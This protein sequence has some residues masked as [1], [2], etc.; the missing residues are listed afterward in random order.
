MVGEVYALQAQLMQMNFGGGDTARNAE[1]RA[2]MT[3]VALAFI[4]IAAVVGVVGRAMGIAATIV[5]HAI[6]MLFW[7]NDGWGFTVVPALVAVVVLWII[8]TVEANRR[9]HPDA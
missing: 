4:V 2:A 8:W 3:S 7:F 5:A 6:S 9:A 1:G